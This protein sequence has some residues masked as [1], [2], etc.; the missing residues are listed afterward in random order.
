M[1]IRGS[2]FLRQW[3]VLSLLSTRRYGISLED[4]AKELGYH[5]RTLRRDVQVLEAAGFLLEH[6]RNPATRDVILRLPPG[7]RTPNVPFTLTEVLAIYFASG[8]LKSL[9][10]TPI[11]EGLSTALGKIEKAL[12]VHA[13]SAL[14]ELQRAIHVRHRP[15]RDYAKRGKTLALLQEAVEK[16]RKVTLRYRAYGWK[17][18]VTYPFRPYGITYSAGAL[19]IVGYSENRR[20]IRTLLLDRIERASIRKERFTLPKDFDLDRFLGD[21]F[22]IFREDT[23]HDVAIEFSPDEAPGIKEK[24]WHPTQKIRNLPNGGVRLTMKAS[25]LPQI[26]RWV[27]SY[28]SGARVLAPPD[29]VKLVSGDLEETRK[30]YRKPPRPKS[31]R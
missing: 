24:E 28:G 3:K 25:G 13:L 19:Y 26:L 14:E 17:H 20:E 30:Q 2:Q 22:G 29:L 4:L 5:H 15:F 1:M 7:A 8:L 11:G 23:T 18:A 31:S 9:R 6:H 16:R 27:L 21:S 12:P 10:T